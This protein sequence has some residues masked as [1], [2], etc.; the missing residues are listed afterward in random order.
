VFQAQ[1]AQA[2]AALQ[3]D[4]AQLENAQQ[5]QSRAVR[6]AGTG[7]GTAQAVDAA[8]ALVAVGQAA[9][10]GDQAAIDTA[11]LNLDF[12]T[13]AAP[14]GG[15]VGLRQVNVGAIIR[16]TD[17]TGIVTITQ[18]Q[19]I[20][21]QFSLPQDELPAILAGQRQSQLPVAVDSRDGQHHLADGKL[22]VIDSQVD[23][24]TGMIRLKAVFTN[25]D[26]ALWPGELVSA[27]VRITTDP[28]A[29]VVPSAAVQNGPK[30]QFVFVIKSDSTV[31][32]QPV[33]CGPAVENYTA[34]LSGLKKGE[35]VV[36]TGQSR[37]TEGTLVA[38]S[39]AASMPALVSTRGAL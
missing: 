26:Q 13:V 27:R 20:S 36:L 9:I 22:A 8:K 35:K 31:T 21:V 6:L 39:E 15:R 7:S 11:K 32:V 18:M 12:A 14:V 16:A 17:A 4:L 23:T 37:L 34:L 5:Q 24:T 30:G 38:A 33:T 3:R 29:T 19:P 25:A 1:L 28:N 10:A 2:G